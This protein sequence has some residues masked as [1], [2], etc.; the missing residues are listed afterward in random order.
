LIVNQLLKDHQIKT[1]DGDIIILLSRPKIRKINMPQPIQGPTLADSGAALRRREKEIT[2]AGRVS[3]DGKKELAQLAEFGR[4]M[5]GATKKE[6]QRQRAI[7][8]QMKKMQM[9][10]NSRGG[11]RDPRGYNKLFRESGRIAARAR[12]RADE[13][14]AQAAKKAAAAK[15]AKKAKKA[16][17]KAPAKKAAK[18]AP[19][20]KAAKKTARPVKK[21]A[22]K[23]R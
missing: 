14:D 10:K 11:M 23:S 18:K 1:D 20:K 7:A 13:R 21:A 19:A 5:V 2:A 6:Q 3:A 8:K 22:K 15:K 16:A 4:R 17:K 12:K 9:D